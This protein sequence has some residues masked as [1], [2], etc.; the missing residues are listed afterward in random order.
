M[1]IRNNSQIYLLILLVITFLNK[2]NIIFLNE[3]LN[4]EE[5]L[6]QYSQQLNLKVDSNIKNKFPNF[7]SI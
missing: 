3:C 2:K 6:C 5:L 4:L 7:E 1:N